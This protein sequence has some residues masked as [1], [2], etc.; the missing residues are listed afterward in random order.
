LDFDIVHNF[1]LEVQ[2]AKKIEE[3]PQWNFTDEEDAEQNDKEDS[4]FDTE[5]EED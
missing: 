1:K 2:P 4:E 5:S 3:H